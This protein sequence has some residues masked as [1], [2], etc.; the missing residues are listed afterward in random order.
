MKLMI[1]LSLEDKECAMHFNEASAIVDLPA[2]LVMVMNGEI[3]EEAIG[4]LRG[5]VTLFRKVNVIVEVPVDLA[6]TKMAL[7]TFQPTKVEAKEFVTLINEENVIAEAL[8]DSVT[9]MAGR[10]NQKEFVSRFKRV[11]AIVEILAASVTFSMIQ[12]LNPTLTRLISTSRM[13]SSGYKHRI[14]VAI[15]AIDFTFLMML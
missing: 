2:N 8:A 14:A 1:F 11:N 9:K 13:R 7:Q 6:T 15:G 4:E 5:F 3:P 10:G 12:M